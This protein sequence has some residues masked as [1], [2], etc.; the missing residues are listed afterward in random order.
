M[1]EIINYLK[2]F[3]T[4]ENETHVSKKNSQVLEHPGDIIQF[5][6]LKADKQIV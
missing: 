6:A 3:T 4:E 5:S 2:R 1:L